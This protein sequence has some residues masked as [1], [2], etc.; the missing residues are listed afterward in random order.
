MPVSPNS[1]EQSIKKRKM[2]NI[3]YL[4]TYVQINIYKYRHDDVGR[5][6]FKREV[7]KREDIK[8]LFQFRIL[9]FDF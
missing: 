3:V 1:A 6:K 9:I 8:T 2:Q 5:K 4:Y 7:M